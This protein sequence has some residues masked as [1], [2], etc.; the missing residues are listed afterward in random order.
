MMET[1]LL[2]EPGGAPA[3]AE[4]QV[5]GCC[6]A[7]F[8]SGD[9]ARDLMGLEPSVPVTALTANSARVCLRLGMGRFHKVLREPAVRWR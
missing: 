1:V 5:R 4:H 2:R 3:F 9:T 8:C 7:P 6:A